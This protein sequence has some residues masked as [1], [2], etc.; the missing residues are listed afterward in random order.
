VTVTASDLTTGTLPHAQLPALLSGDIP[1]NA[2]NTSGTSGNGYIYKGTIAL[3]G[4]ITSASYAN[5]T[6]AVTGATSTT[7]CAG[8]FNGAFIGVTGF[9]PATTGML[10][11]GSYPTTG[12]CNFTVVNNTSASITLPS[13]TLNVVAF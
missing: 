11:I 12:Y 2:A 4:T 9:I 6:V 7:I 8:S 5:F 3:S 13:T 1:N 10:A